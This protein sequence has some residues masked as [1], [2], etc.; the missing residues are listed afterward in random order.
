VT[1][2]EQDVAFVLE[3]VPGVLGVYSLATAGVDLEFAVRLEHGTRKL[4]AAHYA[5]LRVLKR[6][7]CHRVVFFETRLPPRL[8]RAAALPHR[9]HHV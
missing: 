3:S 9:D 5:L 4:A 1:P 8:E 7:E 2:R 6:E